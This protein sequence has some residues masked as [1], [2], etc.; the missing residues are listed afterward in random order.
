VYVVEE[1]CSSGRGPTGWAVVDG[2]RR[3]KLMSP[4]KL[5]SDIRKALAILQTNL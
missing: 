2:N 1:V 5:T 4:P 3:Q